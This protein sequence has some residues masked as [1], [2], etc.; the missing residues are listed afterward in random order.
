VPNRH[1]RNGP[2][3]SS[4]LI[5]I[6]TTIAAKWVVLEP[7]S[8]RATALQSV[9][10]DFV[11]PSL[12]VSELGNVLRRKEREGALSANQLDMGLTRAIDAIDQF[13]REETL[14]SRAVSLSRQF[15]HSTYDCVFLAC[16]E[17]RGIL[18]TADTTFVSK[19]NDPELRK[20]VISLDQTS[21]ELLDAAVAA[22]CVGESLLRGMVALGR[23][24]DQNFLRAIALQE[25]Q[26]GR[27]TPSTHV[28]ASM[29]AEEGFAGQRIIQI[30]SNLPKVEQ[31]DLI[32]LMY[33]GEADWPR[34]N[35]Y[36]SVHEAKNLIDIGIDKLVSPVVFRAK[37]I[38]H[39]MNK[40]FDQYVPA[41]YR[42]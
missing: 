37:N 18:V 13:V 11:A 4:P 3:G 14:I 22:C 36:E 12:L 42:G 26:T 41:A 31:C 35:W 21:P 30:L 2:S 34:Q 8:E 38:E 20:R 23:Q 17:T 1:R 5:V 16:A 29:E 28:I 7:D 15:N 24:N 33:F 19:I 40:V 25:T 10:R 32:A 39:G 9:D 27:S 6:D